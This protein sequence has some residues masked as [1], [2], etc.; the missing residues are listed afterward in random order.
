[1]LYLNAVLPQRFAGV[2]AETTK[3][4]RGKAAHLIRDVKFNPVDMGPNGA[5][6]VLA[7]RCPNR[8]RRLRDPGISLSLPD[9]SKAS[10]IT[11][12][13]SALALLDHT[14]HPTL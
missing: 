4:R 2:I 9:F 10:R 8:L 14:N 1:M 7:S 11:L 12:S 6:Y 5:L 3:E 13:L